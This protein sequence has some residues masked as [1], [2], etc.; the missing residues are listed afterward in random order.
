MV[1]LTLV[2]AGVGALAWDL[3]DLT[4]IGAGLDALVGALVDLT[5]VGAGVGA[6]VG[7]LVDLTLVGA[8]IVSTPPPLPG[9]RR[10]CTKPLVKLLSSPPASYPTL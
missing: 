4:L 8:G 10:R 2:G 3:V 6:L 5:L 9:A 1:D 7:A